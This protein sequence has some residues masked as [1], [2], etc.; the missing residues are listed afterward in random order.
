M[1]I[2]VFGYARLNNLSIV[3]L[4]AEDFL[5]LIDLMENTMLELI[6]GYV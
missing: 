1:H 3:F 2:T 5:R 4:I 6:L